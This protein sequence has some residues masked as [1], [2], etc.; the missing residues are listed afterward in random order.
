MFKSLGRI[1]RQLALT[2][3]VA[4]SAIGNVS[5]AAVF[6]TD[7]DPIFNGTFTTH[8]GQVVGWKGS[9]SIDVD[10]ACLAVGVTVTFPDGCGTVTLLGYSLIFYDTLP[11][12]VIGGQFGS[13][14]GLPDPDPGKVSF[15][16]LGVVDGMILSGPITLIPMTFGAYTYDMYLDFPTLAG[17]TL[18]MVDTNPSCDVSCFFANDVPP[19]VTWARVPEPTSLA[20]F[21]AALMA[22][23]FSRRR[24]A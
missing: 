14:P 5:H 4:L 24:K 23:G 22:M 3:G 1:A 19:T 17:P 21:G 8:V 15:D 9:A 13:G 11:A 6:V 18:T 7:W 12:T 2:A 16:L 20:L 10:N